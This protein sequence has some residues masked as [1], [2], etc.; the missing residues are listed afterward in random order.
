MNRSSLTRLRTPFILPALAVALGTVVV[1][2]V[3]A[4]T[5]TVLHSFTATDLASGAN[6]DG[7]NPNGLF[8]SDNT[9]Y[10]TAGYGGTSG[11]GTVFALNADRTGF[12][13]LHNLSGSDGGDASGLILSG[14]IVYGVEPLGGGPSQ[15]TLFCVN[16]DGTGFTNFYTFIPVSP[17]YI[18]SLPTMTALA[19]ASWFYRVILFM[20]RRLVLVVPAVARCL[21]S[22]LM[23]AVLGCCTI[24]R[25]MLTQPCGG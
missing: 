1:A 24:L 20:E 25:H 19:R 11:N 14:N 5:F 2:S 6:S 8:L 4:Q 17:H 15:G 18:V 23:E 12:T 16:A 7:A 21:S 3:T 22:T 10:G 9:L 13:V